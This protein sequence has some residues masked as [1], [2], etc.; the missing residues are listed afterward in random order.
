[1]ALRAANWLRVSPIRLPKTQVARRPLRTCQRLAGSIVAR[2]LF[3]AGSWVL[4]SG[5]LLQ[6]LPKGGTTLKLA[7]DVAFLAFATFYLHA[8]VLK[9][10]S[11][12][13][14]ADQAYREASI[15][16]VERLATVGE[17]RDDLTGGH[18]RRIGRYA[19][20]LGRRLGLSL[21]DCDHLEL[22]ACIHDIGKVAI[23]DAI[24]NKADALTPAER[25]E[26]E[27]HVAIGAKMLQGGSHPLVR[28]AHLVALTHHENWDGSG[29][30][31]GLRGEEIPLV[32][33][34][35]AVC[36]VYDALSS[37]R[38]YKK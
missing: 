2:F 33:R 12:A 9:A 21:E 10:L 34:I 38:P 15:E 17:Y 29:Y 22:A 8:K 27:T 18:A 4:V 14:S 26:M 36:D 11:A 7:S 30:P 19:A 32:G 16:L 5:T 28:I 25:S 20:V 31:Q 35:V 37:T 24:L 6:I 1:M 3:A 13:E 23:P